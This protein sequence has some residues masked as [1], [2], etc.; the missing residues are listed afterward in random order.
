MIAHLVTFITYS[1]DS[2]SIQKYIVLLPDR[3][4]GKAAEIVDSARKHSIGHIIGI[5]I[6]DA[7]VFMQ[8]ETK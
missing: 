6:I 5:E 3:D 1:E 8:E 4:F 2:E 7:E